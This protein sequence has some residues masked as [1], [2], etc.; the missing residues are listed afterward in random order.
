MRPGFGQRGRSDRS[1]GPPPRR[2]TGAWAGLDRVYLVVFALLA[3]T[4]DARAFVISDDPLE[5]RSTSAGGSLRLYNLVLRGGLLDSP[6]TSASYNPAAVSV[7]A[8]RLQLELRGIG[9][10]D[11]IAHDELTSTTSSVP[12][13]LLGGPLSLGQ[14]VQAPL[15]LPLEGTAVSH[16]SYQLRDRIDWLYLRYGAE[17]VTFTLGR[18][19]ITIGRG[20][21]WTPE[22]L[23]APFS[24][25]QI[26][27][28]Y[29]PGADAARIDWTPSNDLS[30]LLVAAAAK[31]HQSA[32][33]AHAELA[34]APLRLGGMIGW[35][36][37]DL[38]SG[39]DLFLDLGKGTDL[40]GEATATW[41][42]S[43]ER[44]PWGHRAFA[45]A[46]VGTTT[47][48]STKLHVTVELSANG[49]AAPKPSGYVRELSSPRV[50]I[51]ESYTAGR[52]HAGVAADWEPHPLVTVQVSSISN[53]EDPS[54][55]IAAALHFNVSQNALLIAGTYLPIGRAPDYSAG[56]TARSEFG[57]YPELYHLDAKLWF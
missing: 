34:L 57:L 33:L 28:E 45:R 54:A 51:G 3:L 24:P 12:T 20:R 27:T 47:E 50:A 2:R 19:P 23:I 16:D 30:V 9:G 8:F 26:D 21:I 44:R 40:H 38:V 22:D 39:L 31:A 49:A 46:V 17:T 56:L 1:L 52:L 29:K 32:L 55:I 41:V 48:L 35:V 11:L 42:T 18:Q 37:T 6:A 53:L 13:Q 14:G 10:F 43:E 4:R 5:G 25:L 36:R 7:V 15:W